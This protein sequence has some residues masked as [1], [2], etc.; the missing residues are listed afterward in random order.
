MGPKD[1]ETLVIDGRVMFELTEDLLRSFL[2]AGEGISLMNIIKLTIRPMPRGLFDEAVEA[3]TGCLVVYVPDDL[4]DLVYSKA[5]EV[6]FIRSYQGKPSRRARILLE[7]DVIGAVPELVANIMGATTSIIPNFV[8]LSTEAISSMAFKREKE[9]VIDEGIKVWKVGRK[10]AHVDLDVR[11]NKVTLHVE[12]SVCE[13]TL[14]RGSI[15]DLGMDVNGGLTEVRLNGIRSVDISASGG[16]VRLLCGMVGEATCKIEVDRGVAECSFVLSNFE[17][18]SSFN[19]DVNGGY[20]KTDV[21]LSRGTKV[22]VERAGMAEV[23][24]DG[25]PIPSKFVE[26]GY[27]ASKARTEFKG[28]FTGGILSLNMWRKVGAQG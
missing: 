11:G 23:K 16:Y 4:A 19:V 28:N 18:T 20:A 9:L 3:I 15:E 8:K 22:K 13:L 24:L 6:I 21:R 17:G 27:Q 14:T 12:S 26:E 2:K 25:K 1:L 5:R 7:E 10:E